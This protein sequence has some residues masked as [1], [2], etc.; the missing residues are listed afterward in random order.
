MFLSIAIVAVV[1][2]RILVVTRLLLMVRNSF[3]RPAHLRARAHLRVLLRLIAR[4]RNVARAIHRDVA[5]LTLLEA[6]IV[7]VHLHPPLIL[8][9]KARNL[10]RKTRSVRVPGN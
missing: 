10:V 7:H 2:A 4:K 6:P 3:I 9:R 8:A 5:S 1:F